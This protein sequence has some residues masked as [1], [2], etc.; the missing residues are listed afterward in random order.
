MYFQPRKPMSAELRELREKA[1]DVA[2]ELD[3]EA[4]PLTDAQ[5]VQIE[6]IVNILIENALKQVANAVDKA[7]R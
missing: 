7:T 6:Y 3:L 2:Q 1:F 4:E 5:V